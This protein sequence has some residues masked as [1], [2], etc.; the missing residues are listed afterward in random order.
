MKIKFILSVLLF[1]VCQ[2]LLTAQEFGKSIEPSYFKLTTSNGLIVAAYNVKENR[3]DYVY[4]HI[5]ANYDSGKYV[6][7]FVGNIALKSIE[8]PTYTGYLKNT[9]VITTRYNGF[10]VNYFSSFT[11]ND[12]IF[13]IVIRGKKIR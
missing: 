13:Y 9:H 12:K 4:P 8:R 1:S 3:I 10:A 11:N 7:P 6:H 5:F 2:L